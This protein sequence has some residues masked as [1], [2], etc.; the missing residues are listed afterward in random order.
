[1]TLAQE[2]TGAHDARDPAYAYKTLSYGGT[3]DQSGEQPPAPMLL[4]LL[5]SRSRVGRGQGE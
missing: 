3:R 1:M 2:P 5:L 4:N